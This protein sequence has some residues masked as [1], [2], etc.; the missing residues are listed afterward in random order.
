MGGVVVG[1]GIDGYLWG[2]M[3]RGGDGMQEEG[4]WF[5][6]YEDLRR[7]MRSLVGTNV[8]VNVT[9]AGIWRSDDMCMLSDDV[10][11]GRPGRR[12]IESFMG[13]GEN[14][15]ATGHLDLPGQSTPPMTPIQARF[16]PLQVQ[17]LVR[18]WVSRALAPLPRLRQLDFHVGL[19]HSTTATS[20]RLPSTARLGD[21]DSS[22]NHP[23]WSSSHVASGERIL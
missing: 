17:V 23:E 18:R 21:S 6:I 20:P 2:S 5:S 8:N 16:S 19:S 11:P 14:A 15:I 4:G 10:W 9:V 12:E 1:G 22:L 13:S 3:G 7:W